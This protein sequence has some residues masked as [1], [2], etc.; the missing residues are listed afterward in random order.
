L[1]NFLKH[2][3][4]QLAMPLLKWYN[5]KYTDGL[6]VLICCKNE[7]HNIPL[8]L[9]S[10]VAFADQIICIDNGSEDG[11]LKKIHE[12]KTLHPNKEIHIIEAP[13]V[14]LKIARNRGLTSIRHKWL[15][16]IGGDFVFYYSGALSFKKQLFPIL[17]S[18]NLF[19]AWKLSFINLYGDFHH[20]YST[21]DPLWV[22]EHYLFR[23][24]KRLVFKEKGKFDYLAIPPYYLQQQS[25]QP[26]FIHLDGLKAD[27]RLLYRNAYF[28]WRQM[29]NAAQQKEKIQ[30]DNFDLFY[31]LWKK[32]LFETSQPLKLKFRFQRQ[33][34]ALHYSPLGELS[35][36]FPK[37]IQALI[38]EKKER[39]TVTYKN[40]QPYL[41]MDQEDSAMNNFVPEADDLQW[42]VENYKKKYE[43]KNYLS[44]IKQEMLSAKKEIKV[45]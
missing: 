3:F 35:Y 4:Q 33:L 37:N 6:S 2:I 34:A 40:N 23:M 22:G 11:T 10:I 25:H 32:E 16:H 27:D 13:N 26:S 8:C 18:T 9:E 36:P 17:N 12:F 42:D 44:S 41:R 15:L 14:P 43:V 1:I 39:F 20:T 19:C 38:T 24:S 5:G 28:E 29:L 21:H 7:E 31:S 45:T 30:L